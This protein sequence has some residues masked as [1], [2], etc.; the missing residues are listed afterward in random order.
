MDTREKKEIS[1]LSGGFFITFGDIKIRPVIVRLVLPCIVVAV[2]AVFH[3]LSDV[4]PTAVPGNEVLANPEKEKS[5]KVAAAAHDTVR[6][7]VTGSIEELVEILKVEELWDIA[8]D[9][10][11]PPII[12]E[13][14]PENMNKSGNLKLSKKVFLRTMLPVALIALNEVALERTKFQEILEKIG[15]NS[16][17]LNL[18]NKLSG[19]KKNL[20][21]DDV[22]FINNLTKKY[23]TSKTVKLLDRVDI[24]PLS[25]ILSQAAIESY[26]GRSRFAREGNNLFGVWTW[27][28]KGII[29]LGR[30]EGQTHK[31]RIYDSLLE[32]VRSYILILNRVSAYGRLRVIRRNSFDSL[33]LANGLLNYSQRREEYV[34]DVKKMILDNNLKA[35]DRC[36]LAK[37][38][39]ALIKFTNIFSSLK[40]SI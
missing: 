3:L 20:N 24:L 35:F 8:P 6:V 5:I 37:K 1:P 2:V 7:I 39:K 4:V 28:E 32:S 21:P 33:D 30:E 40:V 29:P 38:K 9:S 31:V 34:R 26:W 16:D 14:F 10:E 12:L 19:W 13:R 17:I 18:S 27:G 15:N 36:T 11:I 22:L 25:L 23:R